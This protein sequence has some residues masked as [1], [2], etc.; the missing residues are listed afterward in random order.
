[1]KVTFRH[2]VFVCAAVVSL[3]GA[4]CGQEAVRLERRE[5]QK[6][7]LDAIEALPAFRNAVAAA[8]EDDRL[9]LVSVVRYAFADE[10][11]QRSIAEVVHFRYEGAVTIRTTYD[12]DRKV[13]LSVESLPAYP[14]PLGAEEKAKA[15]AMA[16]DKSPVYRDFYKTHG[17]NG[18]DLQVVVSLYADPR[19]PLYRHRIAVVRLRP[20]AD[21]TQLTTIPVDLTEGLI[22]EKYK[23]Q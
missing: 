4:A 1:M 9:A 20:Q 13:L 2:I 8:G 10:R 5:D 23:A 16:R 12:L 15:I 11:G 3:A 21:L 18:V 14:T 19:H 17:E 6:P 7:I 22:R